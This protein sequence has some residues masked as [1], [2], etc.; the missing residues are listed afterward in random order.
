MAQGGSQNWEHR[1]CT[2]RGHELEAK[3][4]LTCKHQTQNASAT[5]NG[6]LH[7]KCCRQEGETASSTERPS[8]FSSGLGSRAAPTSLLR[9]L[10]E[11]GLLTAL[12]CTT[13]QRC[14]DKVQTGP[15]LRKGN[16]AVNNSMPAPC[17]YFSFLS[18][19][20]VEDCHLPPALLR[21]H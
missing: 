2:N 21:L 10:A 4:N 14:W 8:C 15:G 13:Q 5:G 12:E 7:C 11:S 19:S 9:D 16:V 17:V 18:D 3:R 20:R 1:F 6:W